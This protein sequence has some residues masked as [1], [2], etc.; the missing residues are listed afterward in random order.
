MNID[1]KNK[2]VLITGGSVGIGNKITRHFLDLGAN[3]IIIDKK[4]P[5]FLE[6]ISLK[7]KCIFF[8]NDL[9]QKDQIKKLIRKI[10]AFQIDILINNARLRKKKDN[11][12]NYFS[13][14]LKLDIESHF[15][16]SESLIKKAIINKKKFKICN[17][18]SICSQLI[19]H[20]DPSYHISKSSINAITKYLS[21]KYGRYNI[22]VNSVLPGFIVQD[23]HLNI[24]NK[25]KNVK[26]KKSV[27]KVLTYSR[28]GLESDVSNLVVFLSSE[29]SDFINGTSVIVDGGASN[30]EQISLTLKKR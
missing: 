2:N 9:L 11:D 5:I 17:I 21:V 23:R 25:L 4:Q 30:Q 14:N 13:N 7:K 10:S 26:Y 29:Y 28:Y 8:Q 16:L 15:I 20:E 19:S 27:M 18:S 24:F 22:N 1:F 3:V 6:N 12:K